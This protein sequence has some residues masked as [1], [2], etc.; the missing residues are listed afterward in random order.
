MKMPYVSIGCGALL[1]LQAIYAYTT[2][3]KQ[4]VTALIPSFIGLPIVIAGAVALNEK[5]LKHAMHGAVVFGLLGALA[6]WG[7]F[8]STAGSELNFA[9]QNVLIMAVICTVF[10]GLCVNSFIQARKAK[11]EANDK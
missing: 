7:R 2:A 1:I 3:D 5:L 9:R 8:L 4:S 6:G 11:G 10:V